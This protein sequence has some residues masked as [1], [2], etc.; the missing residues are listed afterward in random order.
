MFVI[1]SMPPSSLEIS[2]IRMN[3]GNFRMVSCHTKVP[4]RIIP[5]AE[6]ALI[7]FGHKKE[8]ALNTGFGQFF[9]LTYCSRNE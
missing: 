4:G 1:I 9:L 5:K 8:P 3:M 6:M 7:L 2:G